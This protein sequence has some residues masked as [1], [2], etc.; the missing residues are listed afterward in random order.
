MP[1]EMSLPVLM[2]E[3]EAAEYLQVKLN[4]LRRWRQ[5]RRGPTFRKM[6]G[7]IRYHIDDLDKFISESI[8]EMDEIEEEDDD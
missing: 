3:T 7:M 8:C 4:T 2:T 6:V 1:L 5:L